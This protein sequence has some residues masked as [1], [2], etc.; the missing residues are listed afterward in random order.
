MTELLSVITQ[1]V[2]VAIHRP[3][4]DPAEL[5]DLATRVEAF[6]AGEP[7]LSPDTRTNL[8][9]ALARRVDPATPRDNTAAL[10]ALGLRTEEA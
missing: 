3:E 10:R 9:T 7:R 2:W 1:G 8:L 5:R 4:P 6:A